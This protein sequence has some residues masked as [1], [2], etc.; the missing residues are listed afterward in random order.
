[1]KKK[2]FTIALSVSVMAMLLVGSIGAAALAEY[3]YTT[4][5]ELSEQ[6][7]T[8]SGITKNVSRYSGQAKLYFQHWKGCVIPTYSDTART[9]IKSSSGWSSTKCVVKIYNGPTSGAPCAQGSDSTY[10][11]I[12]AGYGKTVKATK[13]TVTLKNS[14]GKV[15]YKADG[16]Q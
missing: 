6:S 12:D 11:D 8:A 15:I 7:Q 3:T 1:M 9:Q 2:I 5:F 16:T 10:I 14:N 4:S 13:H